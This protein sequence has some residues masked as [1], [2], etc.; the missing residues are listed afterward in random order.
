MSQGRSVPSAL[1]AT[2]PQVLVEYTTDDDILCGR[3]ARWFPDVATIAVRTGLRGTRWHDAMLHE[4]GHVMLGHPA[5]CGDDFYDQRVEAEADAFAAK[6]A[7]P[8]LQEMARQLGTAGSYAHAARNL[9]TC[10]DLLEV[11][12]ANLTTQERELVEDLVWNIHEG[13][14]A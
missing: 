14:G 4:L 3:E 8:D 5:A 13:I 11:R 10:Y 7:I 12:L 2:M 1:L 6:H 9:G